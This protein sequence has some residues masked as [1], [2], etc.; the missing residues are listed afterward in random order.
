MRENCELHPN[1]AEFF[2]ASSFDQATTLRA[3]RVRAANSC[4]S[5]SLIGHYRGGSLVI[6]NAHVV[7]SRVGSCATCQWEFGTKTGR[8]IMAGYSSRITADWAI[9]LIEGWQDI[10]PVLGTRKRPTSADQFATTGSPSCV[11]PLRQP[12][13]AHVSRYTAS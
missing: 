5:G 2:E 4:G 7:G 3:C 10:S 8:I 9:L 11:W 12:S 1:F 6:T 13:K